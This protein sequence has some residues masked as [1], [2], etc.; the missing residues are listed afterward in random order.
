MAV[1]ACMVA[2]YGGPHASRGL[3]QLP[4]VAY[5]GGAMGGVMAAM[6][7]AAAA[8]GLVPGQAGGQ[9]EGR[10]G[11]E[12]EVESGSESTQVDTALDKAPLPYEESG[13]PRLGPRSRRQRHTRGSPTRGWAGAAGDGSRGT[14]TGARGSQSDAAAI[15]ALANDMLSSSGICMHSVLSSTDS[16]DFLPTDMADAVE[17]AAREAAV[18]TPPS[19]QSD[20]VDFLSDSQSDSDAAGL[21]HD[22]MAALEA[23]YRG[24]PPRDAAHLFL[25]R[26]L[27]RIN[28]LNLFW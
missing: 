21:T 23:L 7:A 17:A 28:R 18:A 14:A 16:M 6:A 10:A 25:Q 27:Y 9:H 3:T 5:G 11:R 13:P 22:P 15:S 2:A 4:S 1:A 8:S 26:A 19:S 20:A 12:G 24:V